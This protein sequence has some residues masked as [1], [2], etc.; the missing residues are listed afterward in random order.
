M[1]GASELEE[2]DVRMHKVNESLR[3]KE[4]NIE[5]MRSFLTTQSELFTVSAHVSTRKEKNKEKE[6]EVMTSQAAAASLD[7]SSS[8]SSLT[9]IQ[10]TDD[11]NIRQSDEFTPTYE[12]GPIG[13]HQSVPEGLEIV[14]GMDGTRTRSGRIPPVW[15]LQLWVDQAHRFVRV[16]VNRESR[17]S[18]ITAEAGR[19]LGVNPSRVRVSCPAGDSSPLDP[20]ATAEEL[21]LF[22]RRRSL[23]MSLDS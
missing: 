8:S 4:I 22:E 9:K 7:P 18:T 5:S 23:R 14:L 3:Q 13:A 6:K 21:H 20:Q 11:G 1:L 2:R 10:I 17:L 19:V 12:W 15:R 16:D